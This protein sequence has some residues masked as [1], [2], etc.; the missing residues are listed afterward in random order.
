M[1]KNGLILS[2]TMVAS[3]PQERTAWWLNDGGM[4]RMASYIQ[5]PGRFLQ[6]IIKV[7]IKPGG[8]TSDSAN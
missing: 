4:T 6:K 8:Q 1:I 7:K 2:E 3:L 5:K